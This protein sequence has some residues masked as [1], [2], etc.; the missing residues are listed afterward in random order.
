MANVQKCV[1]AIEATND[2]LLL[3]VDKA[4]GYPKAPSALI[5]MGSRTVQP[6]WDGQGAVPFGWTKQ[7]T[8]NWVNT[9]LDAAMPIDDALATALQQP[10]AL[11]L[12][13]GAEQTT[14]S[15]ALTTRAN[16]D[17]EAA[18]YLPKP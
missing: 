18:A 17:L 5:G 7:P 2:A 10:G 1:A 12:L 16:K 11:A 3:I 8:A 6:S 9:A 15:V 14:L 13:S 4:L